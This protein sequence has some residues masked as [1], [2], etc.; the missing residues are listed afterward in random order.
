M[1]FESLSDAQRSLII[2]GTFFG[3]L[4]IIILFFLI[5][6]E[7][8][9]R[10]TSSRKALLRKIIGSHSNSWKIEST[11][12]D[13]SGW[14]AVITTNL[15][16]YSVEHGMGEFYLYDLNKEKSNGERFQIATCGIARGIRKYIEQYEGK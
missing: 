8:A 3:A 10:S 6:K 7:L 5:K 2:L 13:S 9:F 12:G 1:N 11:S 15:N 4:L 16:R 14:A